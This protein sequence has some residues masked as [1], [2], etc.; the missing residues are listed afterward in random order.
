MGENIFNDTTNKGLIFKVYKQLMQLNAGE[1]NK[2]KKKKGQ[3][4]QTFS[5]RRHTYGK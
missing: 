3:K 4:T 5:Q 2:K 1:E